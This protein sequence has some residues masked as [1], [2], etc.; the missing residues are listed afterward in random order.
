MLMSKATET[1]LSPP[2]T[3][4]YTFTRG[5]KTWKSDMHDPFEL[6]ER[7][8]H[9]GRW[10]DPHG[11]T[12]V[13]A[14]ITCTLPKGFSAKH[15]TREDFDAKLES[16]KKGPGDWTP[17]LIKLWVSDFTHSQVSKSET[18]KLPSFQMKHLIRFHITNN[19]NKL[20]YA[21]MLNP[22]SAGLYKVPTNW[23]L[24]LV[25][26]NPAIDPIVANRTL[27][28]SFFKKLAASRTKKSSDIAASSKFQRKTS[29]RPEKSSSELETS[30]KLVA[31]SILNM[32]SW[33][34]VNTK[35]YIL[36]SNLGV[37]HKVLVND[38]QHDV[39]YL[40]AAYEQFIPPRKEISAVS[41][42]RIFATPEEYVAYVGATHKWSGGLWMPS[43]REMII[44]PIDWGR[45]KD[46]RANVKRVMYHEAFHQYIS[47]GMPERRTSAWFNEGHAG[48]FENADIANK[49]L[50]IKEDKRKLALLDKMIRAGNIDIKEMLFMTYEQ[51]YAGGDD[52]RQQNYCL[53][54]AIVYY[55]RKGSPVEKPATNAGIM[56]AY[57][58]ALWETRDGNQATETAFAGTTYDQFTND[59]LAFWKS[60]NAQSAAKRNRLFKTFK[61]KHIK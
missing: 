17:E 28:T 42:I 45:S 24:L 48:F 47:Y 13:I 3:H 14:S 21:F 12:M 55:L 29:L 32:K 38:L 8:Q 53:A 18:L 36:L 1:P 6:W 5:P 31:N 26:A 52:A 57:C 15:V 49:R 37:R 2:T 4:Q 25:D 44:K 11:N 16:C 19:P 22:R 59:F 61:P 60:R 10:T 23:F 41:V 35:N 46:Q 54:W 50:Q 27:T 43:K 20:A 34:Y 33:W 7:T 39:E 51:F 56:N 58:D 30:R 9:A 40:R